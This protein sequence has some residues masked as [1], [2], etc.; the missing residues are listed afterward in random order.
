MT[1]PSNIEEID[2]SLLS[3]AN[4]IQPQMR[5]E[6]LIVM[7]RLIGLSSSKNHDEFLSRFHIL[8]NLHTKCNTEWNLSARTL[9]TP[10]ILSY[11]R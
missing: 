3:N 7:R 4:S 2:M 11:L 6:S 1:G 10:E 9:I 5:E 8:R